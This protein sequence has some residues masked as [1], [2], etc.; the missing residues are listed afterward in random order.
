MKV[1]ESKINTESEEWTYNDKK[2]EIKKIKK[3]RFKLE[4]VYS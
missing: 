3:V 4:S 2:I 1:K